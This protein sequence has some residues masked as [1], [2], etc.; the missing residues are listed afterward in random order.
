MLAFIWDFLLD[1]V[2][3]AHQTR[4]LSEDSSMVPRVALLITLLFQVAEAPKVANSLP[5]RPSGMCS[6]F[7]KQQGGML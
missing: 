4:N 1:E 3:D 5:G 2:R 6:R 7:Y